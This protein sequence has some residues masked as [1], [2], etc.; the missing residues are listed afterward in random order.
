MKREYY[1]N[2]KCSHPD[3]KDYHTYFYDTRKEYKE[4]LKR[5][6]KYTCTKHA[7]PEEYLNIDNLKTEQIL[8]CIEKEYGK[9]WQLE[10]DKGTERCRS[11]YQYGN[12]YN[13]K[14][15][16]FPTGTILKV[17]AEIILGK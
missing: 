7:Y 9:F 3:C 11:G 14:A 6:T 13:A 16:D 1:F 10:K 12:G 15:S 4:G 5:N 2:I 8:I 17:N